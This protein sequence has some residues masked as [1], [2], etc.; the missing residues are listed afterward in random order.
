MSICDGC[1]QAVD[2]GHIQKRIARLELATRYRP[3]HIQTL[4]IGAVPPERDEAYLYSF[5]KEAAEMQKA[6][7]FLVYVVEC[8]LAG[9]SGQHE[10]IKRALPTLLKRVKLSYKPQSIVL[11]S[12]AT[13][14]LIGPLQA[15]GLGDKLLLHNG[16]PYLAMLDAVQTKA[17][18]DRGVTGAR[19]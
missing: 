17:A 8:P 12:S 14:E 13:A 11:F 1:G 2:D 16:A 7:F 6:G 5:E 18:L 19:C 4:L 3:V 10:A 15:A 9:D